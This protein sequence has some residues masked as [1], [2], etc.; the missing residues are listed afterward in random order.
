MF[1][2]IE[3]FFYRWE[4][5]SENCEDLGVMLLSYSI[6]NFIFALIFFELLWPTQNFNGRVSNLWKKLNLKNY[7]AILVKF[8]STTWNKSKTFFKKKFLD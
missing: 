5:T 7:T 4:E 6:L 8:Y 1:D 2:L 3:E